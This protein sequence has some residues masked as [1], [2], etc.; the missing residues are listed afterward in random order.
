MHIKKQEKRCF[1]CANAQRAQQAF[2][3]QV[4][5]SAGEKVIKSRLYIVQIAKVH[6]VHTILGFFFC[7]KKECHFMTITFYS[8][9]LLPT[10]NLGR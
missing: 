5:F 1:R 9:V 7:R 8:M 4:H 3:S 10:R 2:W 6:N